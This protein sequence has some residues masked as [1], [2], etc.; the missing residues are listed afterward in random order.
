[1]FASWSTLCDMCSDWGM[2]RDASSIPKLI[3]AIL[4][5]AVEDVTT[6]EGEC[7]LHLPPERCESSDAS[8]SRLIL[9]LVD[10]RRRHVERRGQGWLVQ[11]CALWPFRISRGVAHHG[12]YPLGFFPRS[13]L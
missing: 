3:L 12:A 10:S 6:M 13:K 7:P 1:M 8:V 9:L 5:L 2:I 4:T 11:S